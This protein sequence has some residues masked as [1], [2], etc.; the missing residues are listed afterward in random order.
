MATNTFTVEL[1][2]SDRRLISRL[3][4]ALEGHR[5]QAESDSTACSPAGCGHL[6]QVTAGRSPDRETIAKA[7]VEIGM[8]LDVMK[9]R[10]V[11][12]HYAREFQSYCNLILQHLESLNRA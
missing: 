5:P 4:D 8:T 2:E 7:C 1:S 6:E 10:C 11:P 9:A 3:C 12:I